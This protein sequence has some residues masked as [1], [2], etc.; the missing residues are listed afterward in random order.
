MPDDGGCGDILAQ[1]LYIYYYLYMFSFY[2]VCFHI[3]ITY[4]SGGTNL[5]VGAGVF[6]LPEAYDDG[7]VGP[8]IGVND[9]GSV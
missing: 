3:N 2:L 1:L 7:C 4:I 9:G 5:S 8:L 6:V